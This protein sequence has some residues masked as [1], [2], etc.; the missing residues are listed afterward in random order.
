MHNEESIA[1]FVLRLDDILNRIRNLGETITDTTLVEKNLRSLTSK[2]ESKVSTIEEKRDLQSLTIFQL[3]G[4]LTACEMRKGCPSEVKEAIFI[5]TAKGKEVEEKEGSRYVSEE[6]EVNFVKKLQLGTRRFI[7]KLPF[8]FFVC[9]RVGHY[10][11]K[12]PH[13]EIHEKRKEIARGN[14]NWFSTR[15]SY[16][17]H[18]DSD[19][20]SDSEE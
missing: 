12:C 13:K 14:K 15:K 5:T 17:T 2:F 16:Y 11:A 9:G 10:A 6:D 8:K 1:S 20:L 4:I 19:G 3:H 18:E 7:A